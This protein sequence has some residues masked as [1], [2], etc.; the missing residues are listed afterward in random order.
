[1]VTWVILIF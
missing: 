1:M